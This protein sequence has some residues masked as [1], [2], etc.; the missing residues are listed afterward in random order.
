MRRLV[1]LLALV[2]GLVPSVGNPAMAEPG[3]ATPVVVEP[4]SF[5]VT[6]PLVPG[7]N[8]VRGL[9]YRPDSAPDCRSSVMV[10]LHGTAGGAFVWDLPGRPQ[11]S[12]ARALAAA[13]QPAVAID[14]IGYGSSDHPDGRTLTIPAHADVVRQIADQL[15]RGSYRAP[16]T[17]PV[18]FSRVGLIGHSAGAEIAEFAAGA[19]GGIDVLVVFAYAH[20]I[21]DDVARVFVADEQPRAAQKDYVYFWGTPERVH[22]Y[23]HNVDFIEPDVLATVDRLLNLT[24]SGLILTIGQQPS[25]NVMPAIRVPV[26]LVQSE[27]DYIFPVEHASK[28]LALFAG[29]QDKALVVVPSAGHTFQIEPNA[30]E[31][32]QALVGWLRQHQSEIPAC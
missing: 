21:R 28:E 27:K 15:R 20:F 4:V 8:L 19:F 5:P 13:G 11:Y 7:V 9:L 22:K 3:P 6:I 29:A 16:Q 18:P 31:T 2:L 26:L 14:E 23:H 12:V 25:R 30:A 17:A 24:P 1:V 32:N 10:L